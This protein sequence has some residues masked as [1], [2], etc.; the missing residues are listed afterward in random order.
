MVFYEDVIDSDN[1]VSVNKKARDG[2][3]IGLGLSEYHRHRGGADDRVPSLEDLREQARE[4]VA[5]A[6]SSGHPSAEVLARVLGSIIPDISVVEGSSS[7]T[8]FIVKP[9]SGSDY[10]RIWFSGNEITIAKPSVDRDAVVLDA[11]SWS[12]G[13]FGSF[14]DY[15]LDVVSSVSSYD[16]FID[17]LAY[18]A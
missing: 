6:A 4:E 17:S 16:D 12:Y 5:D 9:R 13:D 8:S 18:I 11:S 14:L 1:A 10:F 7:G 2:R 3:K 15:V